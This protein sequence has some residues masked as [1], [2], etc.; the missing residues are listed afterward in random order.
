MDP[1]T[2]DTL[3]LIAGVPGIV[4][5]FLPVTSVPFPQIVPVEYLWSTLSSGRLD[6]IG[7]FGGLEWVVTLPVVVALVQALR[8]RTPKKADGQGWLVVLAVL[9]ALQVGWL[10]MGMRMITEIKWT[11]PREWLELGPSDLWLIVPFVVTT[12]GNLWLLYR[13]TRRTRPLRV[14]TEVLLLGTYITAM[15][16]WLPDFLREPFVAP[17]LMA[18]TCLVYLAT[19]VIRL[20]AS[21]V[22]ERL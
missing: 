7:M 18:W 9:V 3:L 15:I 21:P 6:N 17:R 2:R 8:L 13:N 11:L 14:R 20:R 5:L 4:A 1:R 16:F 19:I 22:G 10:A 12:I